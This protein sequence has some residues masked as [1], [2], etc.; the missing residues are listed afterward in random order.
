MTKKLI[1]VTLLITSVFTTILSAQTQITYS[2]SYTITITAIENEADAKIAIGHLRLISKTVRCDFNDLTNTF[3]IK[4]N[5]KLIESY[6]NEKLL[7]ENYTLTSF[8]ILYEN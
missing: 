8:N 3:S 1:L 4:T 2:N 7:D 5:T 6:L